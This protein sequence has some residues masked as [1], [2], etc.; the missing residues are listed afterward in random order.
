MAKTAVPALLRQQVDSVGR[1]VARWEVLAAPRIARIRSRSIQLSIAV[2]S[3]WRGNAPPSFEARSRR[4]RRP[5]ART[6]TGFGMRLLLPPEARPLDP[7]SPYA[8]ESVRTY[9]TS[10][11][12]CGTER[13]LSSVS[14]YRRLDLL[15]APREPIGCKRTTNS[16]L[17]KTF[18]CCFS[19]GVLGASPAWGQVAELQP[20]S[21]R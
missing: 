7:T 11:C 14:K 12:R 16:Q 20:G 10:G 2:F 9:A 5:P 13:H 4:S 8:S 6:K 19:P 17:A 3:E 18:R 15:V 1:D 21:A